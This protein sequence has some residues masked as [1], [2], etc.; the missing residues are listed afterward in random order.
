VGFP[1]L[2][3]VVSRTLRAYFAERYGAVTS[4]IA[5][6]ADIYPRST[7]DQILKWGLEPGKYLLFLGR[8][9][10]EKNCDLLIDAYEKLDTRVKL[11]LAGGSS[12]SDKYAWNLRKREND[13]IRT[14]DWVVGDHLREL[15]TNAMLFVLPSDLEGLSL[16]LLDAMGAGLCVLTSDIPENVEL[17]QGGAGFTFRRGDRDD[18]ARMLRQLICDP[19]ARLAAGKRA[20]EKIRA[21]YLWSRIA[22]EHERA[23]LSLIGHHELARPGVEL[24]HTTLP[25]KEEQIA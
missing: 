9:S 2:T 19:Q 7:A 10:P 5:N 24:K 14:L 25:Q 23:Y 3:V 1:D 20:Q 21:D 15:L 22:E 16:A 13:R 11:V 17:V 8:L 6:G 4:Y 12:Y 18:L